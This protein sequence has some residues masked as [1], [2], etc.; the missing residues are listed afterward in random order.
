[1]GTLQGLLRATLVQPG[2]LALVAVN[3]VPQAAPI[4]TLGEDARDA[5]Q[6]ADVVATDRVRVQAQAH[7]RLRL[8]LEALRSTGRRE[9][10]RPR[11]LD[12]EIDVPAAVPH[13]IDRAHA[14]LAEDADHLV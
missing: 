4:H 6:P 11:A 2:G 5:S 13:P 14:A 12:G 7:P 1:E 8:A 3:P 10:F 9:D